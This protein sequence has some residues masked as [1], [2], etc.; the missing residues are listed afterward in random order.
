M[1]RFT[2]IGLLV[3]GLLITGVPARGQVTIFF[4][5]GG[6]ES[7][8][9]T[10]GT[11]GFSFM[12][13][14]WT[15]GVVG[16]EGIFELYASGRFS[17]EILPGGGAV[18]FDNPVA[19]VRFF[20]VHGFRFAAGTA[21]AFDAENNVVA[22]ASSRQ[23]TSFGDPSNFITFDSASPIARIEFSAAVIDNFAFTA[24]LA[25]T[26]TATPTQPAATATPTSTATSTPPP[27][28]CVGDCNGDSEVTV[29]ELITGVNIALDNRPVGDCPQFDASADGAVTID[30]LIAAVNVAL[31]GC[32]PG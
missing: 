23:A 27:S 32:V 8:I 15:G 6:A 19:S 20:Y 1:I 4:D 17:Y 22:S 31:T 14:N 24:A 9:T 5:N 7:G 25:P 12:G 13:S 30:E 29:D 21:T 3:G 16:T 18:T 26:A 10:P 11:M 2:T 28:V